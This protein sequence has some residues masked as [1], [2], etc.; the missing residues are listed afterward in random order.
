MIFTYGMGYYYNEVYRIGNLFLSDISML[1]FLLISFLLMIYK[2]KINKKLI[3]FCLFPIVM[4][5]ISMLIG[6][7][8]TYI[9]RDFKVYLYFFVPYFYIKTLRNNDKLQ[10]KIIKVYLLLVVSTLILNWYDFFINGLENI[11]DGTILRTFAIGMGF[12][13][14]FPISFLLSTYKKDFIRRYGVII[15]YIIQFICFAS[16]AVSYTRTVWISFIIIHSI[17]FILIGIRSKKKFNIN[18]LLR[19]SLYILL[20][21]SCL[22]LVYQCIDIKDNM[23]ISTIVHKF[24]NIDNELKNDDS[25]LLYRIKDVSSAFYKFKSPKIIFGYGYGDTREPYGWR[26][27]IVEEEIST[28]NSFFYYTWKYGIVLS[29]ILYAIILKKIYTL[30]KK[31]KGYRT[32]S[33]FFFVEMIIGAMS[34]NLNQYYSLSIFSFLLASSDFYIIQLEKIFLKYSKNKVE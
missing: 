33:I 24:N 8:I 17:R 29:S 11:S 10:N 15:Y 9:L 13:C 26:V 4:I 20:I 25:T 34:G 23:I 18:R 1:L 7:K 16:V 5:L 27:G 22:I 19:N 30:Y 31:G 32:L 3:F 2:K 28:E 21:S 14:I 12:S 6:N